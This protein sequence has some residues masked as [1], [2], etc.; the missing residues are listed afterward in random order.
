MKKIIWLFKRMME[1]VN[2]GIVMIMMYMF[3]KVLGVF[4]CLGV[5]GVLINF[6]KIIESL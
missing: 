2:L 4:G 3:I 1:L 5:L 6:W